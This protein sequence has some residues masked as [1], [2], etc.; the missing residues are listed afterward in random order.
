MPKPL[1]GPQLT[2]SGMLDNVNKKD[3]GMNFMEWAVAQGSR[4]NNFATNPEVYSQARTAYLN[5]DIYGG[6]PKIAKVP[7]GAMYSN[8]KLPTLKTNLRKAK[9]Q[10]ARVAKKLNS[11][12]TEDDLQEIFGP[13]LQAVGGIG[14]LL[15]DY[16]IPMAAFASVV[17]AYGLSKAIESL[18]QD[19]NKFKKMVAHA[20]DVVDKKI[21]QT[22]VSKLN[23]LA[24]TED[25]AAEAELKPGQ[26]YVWT[27]HFDDGTDSKVKVTSDQFDPKAYY[28][29]KNK[30]VIKTDYDW[31]IHG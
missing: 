13:E 23:Q 21:I 2:S 14:G 30:V 29:K 3:E 27:V 31:T 1:P 17:A 7:T 24:F 10:K 25:S 19:N 28:A 5:E 4:F 22:I 9:E 6:I 11:S 26:Y 15:K 12:L 8:A 20:M 18:N 16:G